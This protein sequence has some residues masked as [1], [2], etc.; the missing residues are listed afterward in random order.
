[1]TGLA[2]LVRGR[3]QGAEGERKTD[4]VLSDPSLLGLSQ[5]ASLCLRVMVQSKDNEYQKQESNKSSLMPDRTFML[6]RTWLCVIQ[7]S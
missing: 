7:E 3:D 2:A 6:G 4:S 1:M 5:S